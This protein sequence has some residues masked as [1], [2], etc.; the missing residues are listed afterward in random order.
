MVTIVTNHPRVQ[1]NRTQLQRD[2]LDSSITT[3]ERWHSCALRSM[4]VVAAPQDTPSRVRAKRI[5]AAG[6][7]LHASADR[8]IHAC[9]RSHGE[10]YMN[11]L[12]S[13]IFNLFRP[14]RTP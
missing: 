2:M 8:H 5:H 6:K 9:H 7:Y 10:K 1:E 11:K 3:I 4:G 13:S 14:E 12:L